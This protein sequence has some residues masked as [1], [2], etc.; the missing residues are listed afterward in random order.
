MICGSFMISFHVVIIRE[1]PEMPMLPE[2]NPNDE[3]YFFLALTA[4]Y[5]GTDYI[6]RLLDATF[7]RVII[8]TPIIFT[9]IFSHA[10]V[11]SRTDTEDISSVWSNYGKDNFVYSSS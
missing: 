3:F 7:F 8:S 4:N 2:A 5:C 9:G 6:N 10:Y 1:T 11:F